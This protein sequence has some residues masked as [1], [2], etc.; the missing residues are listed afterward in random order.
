MHKQKT[1][2]RDI[3]AKVTANHKLLV[4]ELKEFCASHRPL[5]DARCEHVKDV[6]VVAAICVRIE[7][8]AVEQ[9]LGKLEAELKETYS[10]VFKPIPHVDEM[11]DS[12]LGKIKLKDTEKTISTR[13]Y[14][15]PCKFCEAWGTLIQQHLD[16]GRI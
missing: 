5:I 6:D 13:S 3:F 15:C 14:S 10:D 9:Q 11:P 1:K 2:L 16:A 8:L 12:V 4:K 7:Q